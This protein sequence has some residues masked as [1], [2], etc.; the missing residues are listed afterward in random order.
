M[1]GYEA[2]AKEMDIADAG[3]AQ[4]GD[5]GNR[6]DVALLRT[7]FDVVA[8]TEPRDVFNWTALC[9]CPDNG[10]VRNDCARH[11]QMNKRIFEAFEDRS[12]K[13]T[14]FMAGCGSKYGLTCSCGTNCKCNTESCECAKRRKTT[15]NATTQAEQHIKDVIATAQA[16]AQHGMIGSNI[17]RQPMAAPPYALPAPL[18]AAAAQQP[19]G[20]P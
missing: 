4:A 7:A 19:L 9:S 10:V 12:L 6:M 18:T 11:S 8:T 20:M 5:G 17:Q 1:V 14:E 3:A 16:Q 15:T 2:T 13:I